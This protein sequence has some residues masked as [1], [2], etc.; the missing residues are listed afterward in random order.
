MQQCGGFVWVSVN[1]KTGTGSWDFTNCP[2]TLPAGLRPAANVQ[3]PLLTANGA[4]W[5]GSLIVTTAGVIQ[6]G[7]TGNAGSSDARVGILMFPVG[8]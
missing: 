1:V 8:G 6:V 7:N 3:V 5:T 4:S 2:Y